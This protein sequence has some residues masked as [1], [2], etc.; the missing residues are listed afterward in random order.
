MKF[1]LLTVTYSGLFYGGQHL[2]IEDQLHKA[3]GF[4]FD[5]L[6]IETKSPIGS[7]V[8]LSKQERASIRQLA[9][10]LGI[11]LAPLESMSNFSSVIMEE[12]DNN[13][14]MMRMVLDLAKD[15]GIDTVKV[16]AAWPGIMDQEDDYAIYAPYERGSHFKRLYAADLRKWDR[17]VKGLQR[18]CDWAAD[19]GI[20]LAI[21]NH[22]PVV[23]PGY[24]DLVAMH[25]EVGKSNLKFCLDVP[26]FLERQSEAYINEAVAACGNR[27]ALTHYGTWN[28]AE[29][30]GVIVQ[31]PAPAFGAQIN[32]KDYFTA[33]YKNGF[34][35]YIVSESCAP[36]I[37]AHRLGTID[38]VDYGVAITLKYMKSM[39]EEIKSQ[40]PV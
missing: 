20:D 38:D 5:A 28:F 33:L 12:R 7:P 13:F 32:Y 10:D 34:D 4:G 37:N 21:Q 30:D 17:A 35:G 19:L 27:I 23:T 11:A 2:T 1:S 22:A 18:V 3:K 25:D 14:A 29:Q 24:E 40:N 39:V 15:L 6:S 31:N 9:S 16:F 36:I 8:D 26:L